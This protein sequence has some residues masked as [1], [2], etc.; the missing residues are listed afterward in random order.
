M[1]RADSGKAGADAGGCT[2]KT[3]E[4]TLHCACT[5]PAAQVPKAQLQVLCSNE[6][7]GLGSAS[8]SRSSCCSLM[9]SCW[10]S[11]SPHH[12]LLDA[13]LQQL[14]ALAVCALPCLEHAVQVQACGGS[15]VSTT[16]HSAV[17][18]AA[19]CSLP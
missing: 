5:M 6:N 11:V 16:C 17:L 8:S 3:C 14:G 13:K 12:V 15:C 2:S 4:T 10:C 7:P 19:L 1:P 18:S 9:Q